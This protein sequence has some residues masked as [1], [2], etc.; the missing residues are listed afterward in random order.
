VSPHP[1][2]LPHPSRHQYYATLLDLFQQTYQALDPIFAKLDGLAAV[3][4]K[5][6]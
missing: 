2:E 1:A 6:E 3:P 5:D 4:M